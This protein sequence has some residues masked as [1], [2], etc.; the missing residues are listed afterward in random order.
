ME[1]STA[2]VVGPFDARALANVVL[3]SADSL[4]ID[5]YVTSLLKVLYFAHGWHLARVNAPLVGQPFEAWKHGPVVRVVYDQVKDMAGKKVGI[6]LN[7]FDPSAGAYV[8]ARCE[9]P[10]PTHQL[11]IDILKSY[12]R[13]HPYALSDMTH[14]AGS[15][16]SI[17]WAAAE[18]GQRPGLRISDGDIRSYFLRLN[19]A[20]VLK[21]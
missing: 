11:L 17:A 3:D 14:D 16:W 12:G 5:I 2:A 7:A 8:L 21:S 6:R 9:L 18:H 15:P 1:S 20:D 10:K 19:A 4:G 13:F